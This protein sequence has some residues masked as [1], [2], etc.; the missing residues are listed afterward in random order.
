MISE[1][2]WSQTVIVKYEPYESEKP[3]EEGFDVLTVLVMKSYV[4]ENAIIIIYLRH[5][6][7]CIHNYMYL[8]TS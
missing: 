8:H 3:W 6:F 4:F 7:A 2:G 5:K 1:E